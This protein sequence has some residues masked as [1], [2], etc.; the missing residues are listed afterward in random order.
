VPGHPFRIPDFAPDPSGSFE[1][2]ERRKPEE[3]VE[4]AVHGFDL[5]GVVVVA[6]DAVERNL[7][8]FLDLVLIL[9]IRISSEKFPEIN[10]P[11]IQKLGRK[12]LPKD[13]KRTAIQ[14][15]I[16][17]KVYGTKQPKILI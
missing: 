8:D 12:L 15:T 4:Q 10:H 13:Y 3:E 14:L 9:R 16:M 5:V 2:E 6:V 17:I 1:V 7:Q 11:F